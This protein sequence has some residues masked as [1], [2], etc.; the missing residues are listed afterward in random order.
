MTWRS[1]PIRHGLSS[2]GVRTSADGVE[3]YDGSTNETQARIASNIQSIVDKIGF[4]LE[5]IKSINE[6]LSK[7]PPNQHDEE[8]YVQRLESQKEEEWEKLE[9][10]A[11]R[12]EEQVKDMKECKEK[13]EIQATLHSFV[14]RNRWEVEDAVD[15]IGEFIRSYHNNLIME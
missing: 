8:F 1:E 9:D 4:N 12:L 6:R 10:R 15:E 14:N 3:D 2:K 5:E 13:E 7:R 11:E